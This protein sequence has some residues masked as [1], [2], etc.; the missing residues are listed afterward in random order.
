MPKGGRIEVTTFTGSGSAVL[1]VRDS[2]EGIAPE[3]L[4]RIFQPF[5]TTKGFQSTGM[6]LAGSYGIIK[7]HGG[8]IAATSAQG[9][10]TEFRVE[11]PLSASPPPAPRFESGEA[12]EGALNILVVDDLGIVLKMLKLNLEK[13][14]HSVFTASSGAEALE[15]LRGQ[16]VDFIICDLGM[17][18]MNGWELGKQTLA[19]SRARGRD[20]IPFV[21]L[22]GWGEGVADE[23]KMAEC[24]V[25]K[26][27]A[28]PIENSQLLRAVREFTP[29]GHG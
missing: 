9:K 22:T 1:M 24:G 25:D 8:T 16:D 5:F 18:T 29:Q 19:L 23:Q 20:K 26:I 28:K 10:G 2:G 4:P 12:H 3:D 21:M 27:L 17:P 15:L 6:G 11:L 13:F 7:T 14:G